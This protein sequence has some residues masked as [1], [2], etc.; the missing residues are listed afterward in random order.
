MPS[1]CLVWQ[2]CAL[3]WDTSGS[4]RAADWLA[5]AVLATF[6]LA[7]VLFS[8]S[9]VRPARLPLVA[10]GL[11]IGFA[12]WTALSAAWSPAPSLA[13]DDG[14]LALFYAVALL[15]PLVTL[16][17]ATDRVVANVVVVLGLC[18]LAVWTVVWLREA[19]D[20]EL[21]YV[22]GRLDF[23]VTYWNGQAAMALIAFW[24]AIALAAR[25]DAAS[26]GPRA[27]ARR[28]DSD[29]LSLAGHAEQGRRRRAGAS[30][31]SSSSPSPGRGCGCSCRP[32]SSLRSARSRPSR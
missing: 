6:V 11:L 7:V 8:G 22:A 18:A 12:A 13:R 14:L 31:R 23:P 15:T 1:A 16:R 32:L 27:R 24:P 5:Y 30:P 29:G 21:L 10:C 2:Q 28:R 20:P 25:Q 4:I 3:A 17:S 26:R 19:G 9:A